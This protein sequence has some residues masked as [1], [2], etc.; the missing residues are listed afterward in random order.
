MLKSTSEETSTSNERPSVWTRRRPTASGGTVLLFA[1]GSVPVAIVGT[2]QGFWILNAILVAIVMVDLV[3]A[4]RPWALEVTAPDDLVTQVL[5]PA[6]YSVSLV[7]RSRQD[8]HLRVRVAWRP[9]VSVSQSRSHAAMPAGTGRS[10]QV[11]VTPLRGGSASA[12]PVAVRT[13]TPWHLA[14]WQADCPQRTTLLARPAHP[15][16]GILPAKVAELAFADGRAALRQRGEGTEF[17]SLRNYVR[18]DDRRSIDWRAT[19]RTEKVMVRTWQPERDR[20]L[21]VVV[22][23]GRLSAARLS[24][25]TRL[26]VFVDALLLLTSLATH[27]D[28]SVDV[29]A[30]SRSIR[31]QVSTRSRV[32][33]TGQVGAAFTGLVPDLIETD[34]RGLGT[35]MLLRSRQRQAVVLMTTFN[36]TGDMDRLLP[37]LR[38]VGSRNPTLLAHVQ[39][40]WPSQDVDPTTD[41]YREAV[42]QMSEQRMRATTDI[43]AA[44]GIVSL[45][46]KPAPFASALADRYLQWRVGTPAGR[47]GATAWPSGPA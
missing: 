35:E 38:G 27:A 6:R 3:R 26:D 25:T 30:F 47:W 18:G 15:S 42:A 8:M 34:Y 9:S 2:W 19:A 14:A 11:D 13:S 7:S 44:N 45:V 12:G 10:F 24:D 28:D 31:R 4:P 17:D 40:D 22:D 43:L 5:K 23:C 21:L 20:R 36:T 29:I 32:G 33:A 37:S 39:T 1:V 16:A 46:S 41:A